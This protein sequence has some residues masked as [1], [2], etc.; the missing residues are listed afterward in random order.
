MNQTVWLGSI[1]FIVGAFFQQTALPIAQ[2]PASRQL[3]TPAPIPSPTVSLRPTPYPPPPIPRDQPAI[4]TT[5]PP[6]APGTAP[7]SPSLPETLWLRDDASI[8]VPM[9]T[10]AHRPFIQVV[11]NGH[12][13]LFVVDTA[14]AATVVDGGEAGSPQGV[15]SLQI[16]DVRFPRL[17]PERANVRAYSQTYLGAQADGVIGQDLLS[18]YPIM[19]DF[20]NGVLTI[21]HDSSTAAA[22]RP[23][24]AVLFPLRVIDNQ[25]SLQAALDGQPPLWLALQ[26][27]SGI[28][29]HLDSFA[30]HPVH[31][32]H[33][34]PATPPLCDASLVGELAGH[35]ARAQSLAVGALIFDH[36]LLGVVDLSR[37]YRQTELVGGI[38]AP[39]LSRLRVLIDQPA[40]NVA[41]SAPPGATVAVPYDRSG[42]WLVIRRGAVTVH[43][44]SPGSPAQTAQLREGDVILSISGRPATDLDVVRETFTGDPGSRF[45]INFR[46]GSLTHGTTLVLRELL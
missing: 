31:Y 2:A 12:P 7:T 8:S 26:S 44:V 30:D 10:H 32:D 21:F 22:A 37:K 27:G 6:I 4:L 38:G 1:A 45:A 39:L 42:A 46:R 35:V 16:G 34:P 36:P 11:F 43:S 15:S 18:R 13:A 41:I 25:P 3:V 28:D 29:V 17:Q 23:G 9:A 14:S 33:E 5:T 20:P 24:G 19:L 40:G